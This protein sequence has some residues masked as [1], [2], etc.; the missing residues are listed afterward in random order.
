MTYTLAEFNEAGAALCKYLPGMNIHTAIC[1]VKAEQGENHNMLGVTY[2]VG[3]KQHLYKY[4]TFDEGARAAVAIILKSSLYAGIRASLKRNSIHDQLRAIA[5]SPWHTG[6]GGTIDPYYGPL[7]K[8]WG[9]NVYSVKESD[10]EPI[11][12]E[13]EV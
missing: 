9:Y 8:Q 1:W 6:K 7:F 3:G 12:Q 10:E 2:Y 5:L 4:A 13:A 11:S